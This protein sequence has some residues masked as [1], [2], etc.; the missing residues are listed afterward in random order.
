MNLMTCIKEIKS[1]DCENIIVLADL[2]DEFDRILCAAT[3]CTVDSAWDKWHVDR[4]LDITSLPTADGPP[5]LKSKTDYPIWAFDRNGKAL[6]GSGKWEI[7][8]WDEIREAINR[9]D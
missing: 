9:S 1:W 3:N 2:L 4:Y 7:A 6:V 5:D 8:T